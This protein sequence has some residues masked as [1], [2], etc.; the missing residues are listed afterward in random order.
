MWYSY[1]AERFSYRAQKSYIVFN[2]FVKT[3]KKLLEFCVKNFFSI[4]T[5]FCGV[6]FIVVESQKC[7][8]DSV[9]CTNLHELPEGPSSFQAKQYIKASSRIRCSYSTVS[10]HMSNSTCNLNWIWMGLKIFLFLL[11]RIDWFNLIHKI[12]TPL[13]G[14]ILVFV[15]HIYFYF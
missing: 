8:A 1:I 14:F 12:W 2:N 5:S 10:S 4:G 11:I 9:N 6:F 15:N 7:S 13:V 3:V